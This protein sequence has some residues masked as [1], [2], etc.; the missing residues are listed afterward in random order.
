M[1]PVRLTPRAD[2][3]IDTCFA[4]IAKDNPAAALRFLD[5]IELTCD[6]LSRMPGIGSPR[7]A[8]I[9]LIR[10][11]KMLAVND[12]ENYL[13]FYLEREDSIDVLRVLHGS[14]DIPEALQS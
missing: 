4:W 8:E 14:R 11:V 2:S 5:A 13:L 3:D 10:G 1:K 12:F 6:A 9:P 7:Y